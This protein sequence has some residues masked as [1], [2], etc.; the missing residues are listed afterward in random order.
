MEFFSNPALVIS[1][2][3]LLIAGFW[4]IPPLNKW[5]NLKKVRKAA[6]LNFEVAAEGM[7]LISL[8][9]R[10]MKVNNALCALLGY[11]AQ[12][13]MN[14]DFQRLIHPVDFSK[15]LP[16]LQQILEGHKRVHQSTQRYLDNNGDLKTFTVNVS[17]A[18]DKLGKPHHFVSQFSSAQSQLG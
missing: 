14:M 7:A 17:A 6:H 10:C 2:A 9:W 13:L 18:R 11:D 4:L 8:K 15:D 5:F 16:Q 3:L 1:L 12:E